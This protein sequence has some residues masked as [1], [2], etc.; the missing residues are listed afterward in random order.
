MRLYIPLLKNNGMKIQGTPRFIAG[1]VIFDDFDKIVLGDRVVISSKCIFLTHDYSFTTAL[2][3]INEKPQTDVKIVREIILGNNVFIGMRSIIL[4][5][6]T[7]G[8]NVI[9]GAGSVVRGLIPDNSLV[10]GNP[11]H[12]VGTVSDLAQKWKA[13]ISFHN[14]VY[15]I[16]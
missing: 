12:V 14:L 5:N 10:V 3:S 15:D 6:T 13:N 11:C 9:I 2:I 1:D 8:N 4:P 16:Q 7:I